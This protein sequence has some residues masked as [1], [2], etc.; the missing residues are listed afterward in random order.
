MKLLTLSILASLTLAAS[1]APGREYRTT[2]TSDTQTNIL[3]ID[4]ADADKEPVSP[5][6][7]ADEQTLIEI[8]GHP[9]EYKNRDLEREINRTYNQHE[10]IES[11]YGKEIEREILDDRDKFNDDEDGDDD[12]Y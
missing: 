7:G 1:A 11:D 5:D 9:G 6:S 3:L 8:H 2:D 4:T 10:T 12:N